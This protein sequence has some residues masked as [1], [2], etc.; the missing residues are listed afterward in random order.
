MKLL[1]ALTFV[2]SSAYADTKL[3]L[4]GGGKRPTEA[5]K[6]F[7][8][9]A[10]NE[11]ARILIFP[12]ASATTESAELIKSEIAQ[13]SP[14]NIEIVPH[15]LSPK[16]VEQLVVKINLC[17][18]IFFTGGDQNVLMNSIKEFRLKDL[19]QKRFNEGIVF[20]GTS[21]GTAIMSNPMLTGDG[22][23]TVINGAQIGL[24]EGLGLLPSNIIVDQHFIVRSR[25]NR[26]AG[27]VLDQSNKLG[28][29]VDENTAFLIQG[30][31][32]KVIGPTQVL[33]FEKTAENKMAL[34]VLGP[35]MLFNF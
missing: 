20:G 34:T 1:L 6:E 31:T 9:L 23:L 11:T 22:D 30:K 28:I 32:G 17:T 13:F 26:L 35:G 19:F 25:F 33:I 3:L 7:S 12:W 5:M 15:R 16:D 24:A 21:A 2:L 10:G 27:L 14:S 29:G 4:I 18:G 8:R